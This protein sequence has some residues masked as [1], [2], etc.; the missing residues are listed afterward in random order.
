MYDNFQ[1]FFILIVFVCYF[2]DFIWIKLKVST[3]EF[4]NQMFLTKN[5]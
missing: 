4:Q 5:I 3:F 2:K 1:L